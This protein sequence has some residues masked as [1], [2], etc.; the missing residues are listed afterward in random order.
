MSPIN[1]ETPALFRG[2]CQ[3]LTAAERPEQIVPLGRPEVAF[4]GRSNV[5]KSS[6][7]NALVGQKALAR[8][9]NTPGRTQQLNFFDLGGQLI[10]VDL[11]GY[12]FAKV[13]HAMKARWEELIRAYL[14][15]RA[16]L[17]RV[18]LLLDA[19]HGLKD[20]DQEMMKMLDKAA[21]SYALVLTKADKAPASQLQ[22][23]CADLTARFPTHPAC[24]P[25][26]FITSAH[27]KKGL[28]E[29]QQHLVA[30]V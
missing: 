4:V 22:R 2:A 8:T 29:L 21:V 18:L 30:L 6:L 25:Q 19:R 1:N 10:L 28:T 13:S 20:S 17:R 16:E 23:L 27:D 5:G 9:S 3:F 12:G 24:Y 15:G 11:P 7:L 14:G 26:I